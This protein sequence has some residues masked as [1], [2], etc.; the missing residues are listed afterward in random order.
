MTPIP[1]TTTEDPTETTTDTEAVTETEE[2]T[3]ETTDVTDPTKPNTPNT[4][5]AITDEASGDIGQ[6]GGTAAPSILPQLLRTAGTVLA[7]LLGTALLILFLLFRRRRRKQQI[8][9]LFHPEEHDRNRCALRI[10]RRCTALARACGEDIPAHLTT[11]AEKARFSQHILSQDE[12]DVLR[13]WHDEKCLQLQSDDT[14]F[15]RIRH[16]WID[17]YY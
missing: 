11:L 17:L 10:Y 7:I 4:E 5:P 3:T 13:A 2:I 16:R 12:L 8:E 6:G 9:A 1:G 15:A 14:A